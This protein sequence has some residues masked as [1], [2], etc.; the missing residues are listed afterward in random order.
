MRRYAITASLLALVGGGAA[1]VAQTQPAQKPP[2]KVTLETCQTGAAPTDRYAVFT[3]S[4]PSQARTASMAMRFDLFER[5]PQTKG[6]DHVALPKWG[7]WERTTKAGVPGFIFTKRV[8][9]L[10]APA[11]YR[12]V[13]SFR[14]YDKQGKV[15]R[16][17]RRVSPVCKQPDPRPDLHV[18]R[19]FFD[20][21][22]AHVVVRNRGRGAA[23]TFDVSATLGAGAGLSRTV[24]GL[25]QS[26]QTTLTFPAGR[27]NPGQSA[28][29]ALDPGGAVDEADEADN[30]VTVPCPSRRR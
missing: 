22:K 3:G 2:L 21:G 15:L 17:E 26:A 19:V 1:A 23:G 4:M 29:V 8:D 7:I 20:N 30:T 25:P 18:K 10:A 11:A 24:A 28:T 16:S 12:A 13:V 14:W 6:F 27:C 9:Q 5:T